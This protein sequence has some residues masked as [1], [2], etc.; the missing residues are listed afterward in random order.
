MGFPY[1]LVHTIVHG[2]SFKMY[3]VEI[4]KY[5]CYASSNYPNYLFRMLAIINI[6]LT[7]LCALDQGKSNH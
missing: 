2:E 3:Q 6:G 7:Y 4:N 5:Q 1:D